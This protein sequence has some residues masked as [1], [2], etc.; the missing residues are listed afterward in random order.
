MDISVV[1]SFAAPEGGAVV[2]AGK[3]VTSVWDV[4][5]ISLRFS[6]A[7]WLSIHESL[8]VGLNAWMTETARLSGTVM[9][10]RGLFLWPY[11]V[12][13]G[14]RDTSCFVGCGFSF[15][16]V[17]GVLLKSRILID[18]AIEQLLVSTQLALQEAD[19]P[20]I[21]II[22]KTVDVHASG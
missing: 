1:G 13:D 15:E 17:V 11:V 4:G 2:D 16:E 7:H 12:L 21:D 20:Q 5:G 3:F 6:L 10:M 8:V 19:V 22:L 18:D 14:L 9:R